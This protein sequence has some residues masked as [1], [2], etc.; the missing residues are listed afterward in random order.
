MLKYSSANRKPCSMC[1]KCETCVKNNET[2][3]EFDENI[4]KLIIGLFDLKS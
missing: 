4:N 2:E 3:S 1:K